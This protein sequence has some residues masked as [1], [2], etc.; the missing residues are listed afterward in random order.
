MN[1]EAR[2]AEGETSTQ[3]PSLANKDQRKIL[4]PTKGNW[5]V[6]D[7]EFLTVC[8]EQVCRSDELTCLPPTSPGFEFTLG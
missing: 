7:I 5:T 3:S 4:T 8:L 6:L 2:V 1:E